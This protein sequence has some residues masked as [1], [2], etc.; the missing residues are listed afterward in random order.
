MKRIGCFFSRFFYLSLPSFKFTFFSGSLS[1]LD[2][3]DITVADTKNANKI[4]GLD[5]DI[6]KLDKQL[7]K[8]EDLKPKGCD[9][10]C[11]LY[12]GAPST[13]AIPAK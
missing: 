12:G 2:N 6:K 8:A 7:K 9:C 4:R 10:S 5:K 3:L 1:S 13:A 11:G